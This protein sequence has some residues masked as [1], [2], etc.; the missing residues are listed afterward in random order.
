MGCSSNSNYIYGERYQKKFDLNEIDIEKSSKNILLDIIHINTI[1]ST[2]P[3]SRQFIDLGY[4]NPFIYNTIIQT[5]GQ[6]KGK[7]KWAGGI[8]GNLYTSTGIP[9]NMIK[10]E[11]DSKDSIVKITAIS[12]IQEL[13]KINRNDFF[14][15]YPNDILCIE[16]KKMGGI[17]VEPYKDFYIIGFG[18]NVKEKPDMSQIRKEGLPPCCI[19]DHLP[20]N[21]KLPNPLDLSIEITKRLIFNINLT[22]DKINNL[23]EQYMKK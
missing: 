23:F 9:K 7:R 15:K 8:I 19:K 21:I 4:K 12:I 20:K 3:A 1:D 11:I 10:N 13:L 18:I 5:N 6:G 16:N 22:E 14:L 17:L 2:M